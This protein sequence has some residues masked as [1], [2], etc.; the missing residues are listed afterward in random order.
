LDVNIVKTIVNERRGP[1]QIS[2]IGEIPLPF[3]SL[4]S[5]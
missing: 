2:N 3:L 4:K 1:Q 5:S